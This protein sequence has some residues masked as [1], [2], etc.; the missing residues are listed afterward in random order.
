MHEEFDAGFTTRFPGK[1]NI[2][3]PC[4]T[5]TAMGPFHEVSS[6]GHKKLAQLALRMGEIGLLMYGYKDKWTDRVLY[7]KLLP[8]CRTAAA[9][10]HFFLDFVLATGC[11]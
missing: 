11:E 6:D 7:L 3:I 4:K 8:N 10:G 5:L 2:H 1:K 9:F